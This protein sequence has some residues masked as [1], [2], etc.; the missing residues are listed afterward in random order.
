[1]DHFEFAREKVTRI[2]S[3][4]MYNQVISQQILRSLFNH[5]NFDREK[6]VTIHSKIM[7]KKVICINFYFIIRYVIVDIMIILFIMYIK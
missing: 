4:L 7:Y 2:H 1:M 3:E 5:F 6:L